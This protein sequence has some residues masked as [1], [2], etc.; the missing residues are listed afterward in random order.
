MK[1]KFFKREKGHR[2]WLEDK[3]GSRESSVGSGKVM[4]EGGLRH[5]LQTGMK[6]MQRSKGKSCPLSYHCNSEFGEESIYI[7]LLL[8][9]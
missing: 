7:Q 9:L 2:G 4:R 3:V 6:I 8:F 1:T 5:R